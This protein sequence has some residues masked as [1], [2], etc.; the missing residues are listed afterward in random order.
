MVMVRLVLT[1][2]AAQEE[3]IG[4]QEFPVAWPFCEYFHWAHNHNGIVQ[5][6]HSGCNDHSDGYHA[7]G[8]GLHDHSECLECD[9]EFDWKVSVVVN[10]VE[11]AVVL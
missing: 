10:F 7:S 8:I 11:L 3:E 1:A 6:V 9:F 5:I 4:E 2:L